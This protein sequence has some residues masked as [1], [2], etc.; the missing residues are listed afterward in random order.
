MSRCPFAT[1]KPISG[2]SGSNLGGPFK[3]VHH[4]TEGSS[5]QG[6]FDA[7]R[8]N[9]SDPHFTVDATTIWQHIATAS[10]ARALRNT[11]DGAQTNRDSAV[12]IEIVGFAHRPKT[13][14]ALE[15]VRRLCRWSLCQRSPSGGS[16]V[17]TDWQVTG[18]WPE[19]APRLERKRL[20][21][22]VASSRQRLEQIQGRRRISFLK[23]RCREF[24]AESFKSQN[25]FCVDQS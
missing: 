13:R 12:Q 14:A 2:S 25:G 24:W 23:R 21:W 9:R 20:P 1:W 3:I 17:A 11:A 22:R 16:T 18:Q 4:T 5:A 8:D 7:L 15:N 10:A 19:T 6:A